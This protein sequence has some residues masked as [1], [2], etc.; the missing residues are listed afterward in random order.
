[1][2]VKDLVKLLSQSDQESD[3]WFAMS[4]GCC[5]EW[6][7]L[8]AYDA[9]LTVD[10]NTVRVFFEAIPGYR[11]CIQSSGTKKSDQEYWKRK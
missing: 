10:D 2:K 7:E 8:E 5:G 6:L 1:M 9:D 3:V 11:S 4:D